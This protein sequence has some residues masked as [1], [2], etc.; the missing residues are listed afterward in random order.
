MGF[1]KRGAQNAPVD[2]RRAPRIELRRAAA[3][4]DSKTYPLKNLST[5]GFLMTPYEGDLVAH[6]R[7]YLTLVLQIDGKEHDYL[8]DAHVVRLAERNLAGRFIDLRPDARRLIE[9]LIT[10]R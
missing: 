10:K 3:K 2:R 6:Q 8:T 7:V 5:A 1:L 9:R 4:V